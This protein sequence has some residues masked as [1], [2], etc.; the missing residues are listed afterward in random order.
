MIFY[1]IMNKLPKDVVD[2]I[3]RFLHR[4]RL[5]I[6]L[7]HDYKNCVLASHL[8]DRVEY[9]N[10]NGLLHREDGPAIEWDNGDKSWYFNG[11]LYREDGPVIECAD[12]TTFQFINGQLLRK[13]GQAVKY[14][15]G[16]EYWLIN[17]KMH[18][19]NGS[20]VGYTNNGIKYRYI[21]G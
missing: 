20:V 6:L 4:E 18:R 19:V 16:T 12:G 13:D 10:A 17:G 11:L 2:I 14:V 21:Y 1:V 7:H 5:N 15:N 8:G 9:R 3:Y